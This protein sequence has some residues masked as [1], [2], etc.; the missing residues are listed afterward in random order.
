MR[1][2]S[3]L[4]KLRQVRD[5]ELVA[6]LGG[7]MA[8]QL[9]VV[10]I[11]IITTRY[12]DPTDRG[13]LTLLNIVPS[14]LVLLASLGVPSA[15]TYFTAQNN[16]QPASLMPLILPILVI[17][18][19]VAGFLSYI[20]VGLLV[21]NTAT[22][23]QL[24]RL[25]ASLIAPFIL[26]QLFGL[27]L[28]QGEGRLRLFAICRNLSFLLYLAL[29]VVCFVAFHITLTSIMLCWF[30]GSLL[31]SVLLVWIALSGFST[32]KCP[33]RLPTTR[34]VLDYGLRALVTTTSPLDS[35]KA[36]QLFI[37]SYLSPSALGLYSA[38]AAISNFPRLIGTG[39]GQTAF[40]AVAAAASASEQ[41]RLTRN[42]LSVAA[43][44][45]IAV[46]AVVWWGSTFAFLDLVGRQFAAAVPLLPWLLAAA[47]IA[48]LRKTF[49]DCTNGLGRP[50]LGSVTE[51]AALLALVV[52]AP[53]LNWKFGLPGVAAAM[54]FS[55]AIGLAVGSAILVASNAATMAPVSKDIGLPSQIG[56]A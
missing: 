24:N 22:H 33:S 17:Q 13:T 28:L 9:L 27:A 15:L 4:A 2:D 39:V 42:F 1:P 52:L 45:S 21:P 19:L 56:D 54:T 25:L 40:P 10:S 44:L 12:L 31:G 34:N 41:R 38:A 36:D 11:A 7:V 46:A 16:L 55:A 35:L 3:V 20:L 30:I 49:T 5:T 23:F 37:G 14:A 6:T 32:P 18:S 51:L 53:T 29:L 43:I 47:A 8:T 26:A 50:L 48:S